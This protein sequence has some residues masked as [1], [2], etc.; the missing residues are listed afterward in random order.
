MAGQSI[1]LLALQAAPPR[2]HQKS[3]TVTALT[4]S[5]G[6]KY[7][8]EQRRHAVLNYALLGNIVAVAESTGIPQ[9]TL[10]EWKNNT[11]WWGEL[12]VTV[13]DQKQDEIDALYTRGIHR[14][15]ERALDKIEDPDAKL[16]DLVKTTAILFDKRQLVR[17]Q[18]TSIKADSQQSLLNRISE[19]LAKL[20]QGGQLIE[21]EVVKD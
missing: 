10:Y 9:T 11:E 15:A 18:P 4:N 14:A 5:E 12:L 7:T 3:A 20:A 1:T 17:N 8:D 16:L 13:R 6:S 19:G 21:G 2:R